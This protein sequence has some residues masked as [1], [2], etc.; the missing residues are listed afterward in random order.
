MYQASEIDEDRLAEMFP[1]FHDELMDGSEDFQ[2]MLDKQ[3]AQADS[4]P[5]ELN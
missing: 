3:F 4:H 5:P 2:K 1:E